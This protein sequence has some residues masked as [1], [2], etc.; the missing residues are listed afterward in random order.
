MVAHM[1]MKQAMAAHMRMK[2]AKT[3]QNR[4]NLCYGCAQ[5]IDKMGR[6]FEQHSAELASQA[7]A[8][9]RTLARPA[10]PRSWVV[11]KLP[12]K[13]EPDIRHVKPSARFHTAAPHCDC[14]CQQLRVV[15]T[16]QF[17]VAAGHTRLI[18]CANHDGP[19]KDT[20]S[21][22]HGRYS[23]SIYSDDAGASWKAGKNVGPAGST[24]CNIGPS[25]YPA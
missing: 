4:I 6:E 2:Q 13:L 5:Q 3:K 11:F 19:D 12:P 20:H 7:E 14:H 8:L 23:S 16:L 1:R 9:Q 24:E 21:R 15:L 22:N 10:L 17:S 18:V 25:L